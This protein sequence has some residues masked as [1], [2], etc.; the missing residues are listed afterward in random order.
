MFVC[1]YMVHA[2][3]CV[4]IYGLGES[5]LFVNKRYS[6]LHMRDSEYEPHRGDICS[7]STFLNMRDIQSM[8][9]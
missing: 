4:F 8:L 7:F 3:S 9:P 6:V 2:Q 1:M 5:A